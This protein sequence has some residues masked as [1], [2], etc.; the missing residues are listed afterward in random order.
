MC[1]IHS[2]ARGGGLGTV[3]EKNAAES[4]GVGIACV[5]IHD[6]LLINTAYGVGVPPLKRKISSFLESQWK[7]DVG[8]LYLWKSWRASWKKSWG[9]PHLGN[10]MG[11]AGSSSPGGRLWG[12]G[13]QGNQG[14]SVYTQAPGPVG[15]SSLQG[16]NCSL[17]ILVL[18]IFKLD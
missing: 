12:R 8:A 10:Q 15:E 18:L 2:A 1:T 4:H 3:R 6:L 16:P 9:C 13:W 5:L 17:R 14:W 7:E 11:L